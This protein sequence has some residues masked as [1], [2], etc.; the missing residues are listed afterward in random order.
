MKKFI[1]ACYP[2]LLIIFTSIV[3]RILIGAYLQNIPTQNDDAKR[4]Q[5]W[6][7]VG[8]ATNV[9][10][11]YSKA[12]A[13]G[14]NN[15][16]PGMTYITVGVYKFTENINQQ[17]N[18]ALAMK[19]PAILSDIILG[20]LIFIV[21]AKYSKK[22]YAYVASALFLLN[23]VVIYN[24]T[25]WGQTDSLNN[26]FFYASLVLLLS[27]KYFLTIL[28]FALALFIKLS[29]LPLLPLIVLLTL[30]SMGGE[31]R[32]MVMYLVGA[33]STL[34]LLTLP[35]SSEP[36]GWLIEFV[37]N[38]SSGELQHI[39]NYTFNFW[40]VIFNPDAFAL[41][42]KASKIYWGQ[43]LEIWAYTLFLIFYLP[44]LWIVFRTKKIDA[45][46]IFLASALTCFAM[47][48]FLPRMHE[49]YLYPVLP[50][51][52]TYIGLKNRYY[53]EYLI[54]TGL[55]FL[56]LYVVYHPTDFLPT[57]LANII[58]H[59]KARLGISLITTFTFFELYGQSMYASFKNIQQKKIN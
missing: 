28:F 54:L 44:I 50:L 30:K 22:K 32:R 36:G 49:R 19:I 29:L 56:N 14:P 5:E 57:Y 34:I 17:N 31:Y 24:S 23:P 8:A 40:A 4:Y 55:N 1:I 6:G 58:A 12:L 37:K 25:V 38:N 26:L 42:P 15:Q 35:I 21:V 33:A 20:I 48:I 10:N 11:A 2:L 47:F 7:S 13:T 18:Y 51:L 3:L 39:T 41:V 59:S 43:P 9:S 27:K 45:P 46:L 52:A 53:I 16:P